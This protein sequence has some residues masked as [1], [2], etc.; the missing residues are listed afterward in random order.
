MPPTWP[1][2]R[3]CGPPDSPAFPV[4]FFSTYW[5]RLV[6]IGPAVWWLAAFM[7]GVATGALFRR[8]LPAMAVTLAV[9]ALA[10]FGLLRAPAHYATPERIVQAAAV[11]YDLPPDGALVVDDYWTDSSG[12]RFDSQD[13]QL[14]LAGP[15]GTDLTTTK[16]AMCTFRHGYRQVFEGHRPNRFWQLQWTEAGI[17]LTPA[18]ALGGVAVRRALRPRV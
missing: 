15:C 12:R 14:A 10:F 9:C 1:D 8:T 16:Y 7:L 17:L 6:G 2:R 3:V 4:N 11:D 5:F 18:V 13:V